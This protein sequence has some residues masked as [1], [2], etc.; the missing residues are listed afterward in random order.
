MEKVAFLG[1]G[2]MGS[3]M[4]ANLAKAGYPL[5]VWNRTRSKA[6][7]FS[8]EHGALVA[9]TPKEAVNGQDVVFTMLSDPPAV[10]AVILGPDGVLAGMDQDAIL[11]DSS[12][13]DPGTSKRIAEEADDRGIRFVSA[14][15]G[16]SKQAAI[17]GKLIFMVGG[18]E[19]ALDAVQPLLEKMGKKII[20]TGDPVQAA[21][22]KLCVNLILGHS[23]AGLVETLVLGAKAGL[24][25]EVILEA[26]GSG[27]MASP[28]Y[29]WKGS[30]ILERDFSPN[31]ALRLM[32]K[33][34]FLMIE[35][36][37]EMNVPLPVTAAVKELYAEAMSSGDPNEDF[38]SVVKVL[39]KLTGTEIRR[40]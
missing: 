17:E 29:D 31:F 8:A 10:E 30:S 40:R 7:S 25:P 26:V 23:V 11:A 14:P 22:L 5:T 37:Y 15:V 38:C 36:G 32:Y 18:D 12:T 1:L 35:S 16:G 34:L 28:V 2:I 24:K 21:Q 4:A 19:S 3:G 27:I 39:E 20:R 33:D 9:D 6:D 13:V